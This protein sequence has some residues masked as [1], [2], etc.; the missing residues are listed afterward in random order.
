MQQS[1]LLRLKPGRELID[2][3][4]VATGPVETRDEP[5]RDG[6]VAGSEDDRNCPAKISTP[7]PSAAGFS[8]VAGS[9]T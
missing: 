2:A 6:I 5:R 9:S 8:R 7:V 1:E 3:G 4:Q